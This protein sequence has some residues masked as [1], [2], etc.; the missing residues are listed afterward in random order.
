LEEHSKSLA[1]QRQA[2]R[3]LIEAF[4]VSGYWNKQLRTLSCCRI[5]LH[6]ITLAD[7]TA[8]NGRHLLEGIF[9]GTNPMLDAS[10]H[11]YPQQGQL[12]PVAW[13]LWK[14]A[15][16][17]ALQVGN[18]GRLAV[19]LGRWISREG[20]RTWPSWYDPTTSFIYLQQSAQPALIRCFRITP[21]FAHGFRHYV[22]NGTAEHLPPTRIHG[23]EAGHLIVACD[24]LAGGQK[25]IE[26]EYPPKPAND[27]FDMLAAIHSL[28]NVLPITTELRHVEAHQREKHRTRSLEKWAIWNDE[29]DALA[30]AYW[31]FTTDAA[32]PTIAPVY[33]NEWSVWVNGHK[34]CKQFRDTIREAVHTDRLTTWWL[35]TSR[36]KQAKFTPHQ[37]QA[38][39]TIAPKAAWSNAKTARRRWICKKAADLIPVGRNMRRW[40]FW[41]K[42]NCPRCLHKNETTVHVQQCQDPRALIH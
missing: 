23:I 36:T 21:G 37:I 25:G 40:Q 3:F 16:K 5:R 39:D 33:D 6:A 22:A 14:A 7:I 38:M 2:D 19:P 8:G 34:V 17:K 4:A 41:K 12:P 10:P 42:N 30:K 26:W 13:L 35:K 15:L 9:N 11:T 28:R 29:M 32:A 27:H 24:N 31:A 18:D 20:D 1:L